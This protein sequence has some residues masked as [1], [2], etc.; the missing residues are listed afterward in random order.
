MFTGIITDIG[1]IKSL[2]R[3][4]AGEGGNADKS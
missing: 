3:L 4:K 1:I 2:S